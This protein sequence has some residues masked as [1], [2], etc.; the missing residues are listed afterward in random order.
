MH[1]ISKLLH[2]APICAEIVLLGE[3]YA[4]VED[5]LIAV[6]TGGL[7]ADRITQDAIAI[8]TDLQQI[9]AELLTRNHEE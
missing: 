6:I 2:H 8:G 5:E 3:H 7:H 9:A 1:Q 4:K